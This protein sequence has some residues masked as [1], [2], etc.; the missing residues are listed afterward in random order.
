MVPIL[1]N[2][3]LTDERLSSKLCLAE[4]T[5][6]ERPL[7]TVIDDPENHIT[8]LWEEKMTA[9]RSFDRMSATGI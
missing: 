2:R 4:H 7:K 6:N 1:D 5:I 3:S 8:F 9:L